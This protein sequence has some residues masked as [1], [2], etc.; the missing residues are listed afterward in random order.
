MSLERVNP[1]RPSNERS[2]WHSAA[3]SVGYAT[4]A[5]KNSQYSDDLYTDEITIEPAYFSPDND[6]FQDLLDIC[7]NFKNPG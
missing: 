6:G 1:N 3:A 5:Y 2:N 7:F 4:P